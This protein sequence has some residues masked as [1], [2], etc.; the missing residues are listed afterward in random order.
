MATPPE[1]EPTEVP[2]GSPAAAP[3]EIDSVALGFSGHPVLRGLTLVVRPG[4][5]L[6]LLGPSG[7]GKTTLLRVVAGLEEPESGT[8]RVGGRLLSERGNVVVPERRD[9]AMVF[10]DWA[11]FPHMSVAENVGFGLPRGARSS[12]PRITETLDLVGLAGLEDRAPASLSGGQQQRVALGRALAQRPSVLLLD[13]PFS[14]LDPTLRGRVRSDVRELLVEVGVTSILVTHDRD[15]AFV[16]GD[17]V[18][19]MRDGVIAQVA[20]PEELYQHPCDEWVAGFVG[21]LDLLSGTAAGKVVETPLGRLVLAVE[22]HGPVSVGLRP[23]QVRLDPAEG[24]DGMVSVVEHVEYHGP[25]TGYRLRSP[26]GLLRAEVPGAPR[27]RAGDR[28]VVRVEGEVLGWG[29]AEDG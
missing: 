14:N 22:R 15:E 10:Q 12:S 29:P 16:L 5:V 26:A 23:E 7:C 21:E 3:V 6:A 2:S 27:R 8:V 13:E 17:R 9:I 1:T 19:V 28:V 4:E 18:A 25:R 24:G 20:A 11:L